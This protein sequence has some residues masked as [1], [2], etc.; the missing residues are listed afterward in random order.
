MASGP[1]PVARPS[2]SATRVSGSTD[3]L[4]REVTTYWI[5]LEIS[6]SL[7]NGPLSIRHTF[8]R[9]NRRQSPEKEKS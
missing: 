2:P 4:V 1:V 9:E 5:F 3:E 8:R 6:W 7:S